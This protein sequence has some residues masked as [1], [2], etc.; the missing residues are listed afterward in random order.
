MFAGKFGENRIVKI[1]QKVR[2]RESGALVEKKADKI[3]RRGVNSFYF[4]IFF[5]YNI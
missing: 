5:L 4:S 1:S 3:F 2:N